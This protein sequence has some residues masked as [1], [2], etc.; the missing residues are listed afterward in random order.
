MVK[1]ILISEVQG[2]VGVG[3]DVYACLRRYCNTRIQE[4]FCGNVVHNNIKNISL[5]INFTVTRN[6]SRDIA[7]FRDGSI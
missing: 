1:I 3:M 2:E 7:A 4:Y 5:Q 6:L